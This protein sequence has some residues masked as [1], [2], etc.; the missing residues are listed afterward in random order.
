MFKK[1]WYL[2][3]PLLLVAIPVIIYGY[4][5]VS[6][7]YAPKDAMN[8]TKYFL[9]SGTR[10]A[11]DYNELNFNRLQPGMDG[12]QVYQTMGKQPSERHDNDTRWV[13]SLPKPGSQAYHERVIIMERDK[14]NVPRVKELVRRFHV[15]GE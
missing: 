1:N 8:A 11:M 7:G 14:Q 5:T 12:R 3:T 4:Y 10:Y 2:F 15:P 6:V 9:V 13:Y